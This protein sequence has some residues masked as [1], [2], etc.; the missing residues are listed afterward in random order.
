MEWWIFILVG[1]V[2]GSIATLTRKKALFREHA[3]EFTSFRGGITLVL[4]ALFALFVDLSINPKYLLL[5]FIAASLDAVGIIFRNKAVRHGKLSSIAP[6]AG[7]QTVMIFVLGLVFLNE[8]PSMLQ[9]VGVLIAFLG[10]QM[11][12]FNKSFLESF[13]LN[14]AGRQYLLALFL[15]AISLIVIRDVVQTVGPFVVMFYLWLFISLMVILSEICINGFSD[16]ADFK[17]EWQAIT[18][19]S[20]FMFVRNI[21]F[22]IGLSFAAAQ[23]VLVQTLSMTG[24]LIVTYAGGKLFKETHVLHKTAAAA[25]MVLGAILIIL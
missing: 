24:I 5:L 21:L 8:L 9:I 3:L 23:A 25:V 18:C 11:L 17:K 16:L 20:V 14:R 22:Y 1:T 19:T 15:F 10:F 6:L 13:N 4:L 12:E 7:I 2:F